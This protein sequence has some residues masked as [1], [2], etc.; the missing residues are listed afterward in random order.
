MFTRCDFYEKVPK[1]SLYLTI[2]DGVIAALSKK[3]KLLDEVGIVSS[4]SCVAWFIE[5]LWKHCFPT[6][7]EHLTVGNLY[8]DLYWSMRSKCRLCYCWAS[9][10]CDPSLDFIWLLITT[11]PWSICIKIELNTLGIITSCISPFQPVIDFANPLAKEVK[12]FQ[13][14]L[15]ICLCN[16]F[17]QAEQHPLSH[18][19]FT[20]T[21]SDFIAL[22][23]LQTL[24]VYT[25][26]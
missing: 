3:H 5:T 2:H 10:C 22:I 7:V 14:S 20:C 17:F 13:P 19:L 15:S 25:Y 1:D 16:V 21:L 4:F 26:L 9:L 6:L 8:E 24:C 23:A 12:W 11:I 18:S